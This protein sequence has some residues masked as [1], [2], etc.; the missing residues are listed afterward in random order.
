[1]SITQL[2]GEA[3]W[4][5]MGCAP[6]N[7]EMLGKMSAQLVVDPALIRKFGGNGPRY[8]SYP[9]A[10]RFVE[11]FDASAYRHWLKHRNIG[12]FARAL[13]L[14]VHLPFCDTICYYCGCNKIVTRDHSRSATYLDYLRREIAMVSEGIEGE[15]RVSRIHWGGGTPTFLSDAELSVLMQALRSAFSIDPDGEYAIEVDPR[16]VGI[17]RVAHLASLGFNRISIGVQDFN[18]LVQKAVNRVQSVEE[19]RRVIDA[20]RANGF[21]SVNIDLIYGLPL[22]GVDGF[23][24][25]LDTV[26]ECDPDRIALYSYAHL[27][28]MFKPQRRIAESA[29][30]VPDVKLRL[31]TSA[32]EHLESAGYVY[33]GMD[34]FAKPDDELVIAQRHG[35][36]T[37]DFQGYSS[38]GDCDILGFG[39]SAIG[40]VGPCYAQ[41]MKTLDAYYGA[42]DQGEVPIMRGIELSADDLARR[43]VIQA[44]ACRFLVS[45][46]AISISHLLDFDSYF[47]TEIEALRGLE[48]DG[49][50]DV[51]DEWIHVTPRGRL[52]VR[53]VCMVF[54]RYLRST[55][56][57]AQYSRVV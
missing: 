46:E 18:P 1:M 56:Q 12:G 33:V 37:R 50:V 27:P 20:A 48:E 7:L 57:R 42:L 15:R 52:L 28:G 22:Q 44:L 24:R 4:E 53:R 5:P 45:K 35:R 55:E 36:L 49:L 9:T 14:Y 32:I 3:E 25:T 51:D 8:T 17:E 38:G 29:L 43:A 19:T 30:P 34:H 23:M 2:A 39:V 40:R 54:D 13:S 6:Q 47:S 21:R 11:A 16:K 10:D 26:I 31:L 41:N